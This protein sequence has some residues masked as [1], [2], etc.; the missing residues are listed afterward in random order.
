MR[1]PTERS[2]S[3]PCPTSG[4]SVRHLDGMFEV[5]AGNVPAT[6]HHANLGLIIAHLPPT[7]VF[8]LPSGD[9]AAVYGAEVVPISVGIV[10]A[11]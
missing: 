7:G 11:C 8:L 9:V 3:R 4:A 1:L 5:A 6:I 10:P 2:W